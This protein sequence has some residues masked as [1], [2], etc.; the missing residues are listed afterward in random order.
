MI[1]FFGSILLLVVAYFTYGKFI[2]K[3]FGP[4]DARKTPAYANADGID[5]VPMNKQKMR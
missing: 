1:T 2:E 3:I 4:T 5:Y